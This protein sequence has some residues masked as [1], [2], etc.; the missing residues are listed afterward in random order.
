MAQS[1]LI[2]E[3]LRTDSVLLWLGIDI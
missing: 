1:E 3:I 2:K